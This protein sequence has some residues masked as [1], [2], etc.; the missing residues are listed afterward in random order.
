MKR[1]LLGVGI[2]LGVA[3]FALVLYLALTD[4][5]RY[6]S[7]IETAVTEATGREF[8][9]AGE[10]KPVVFPLS[11]VAED[12]SMA[13]ASWGTDEPFLTI[14]HVSMRVELASLFSGPIRIN[15]L[16]VSDVALALEENIDAENN[17]TM[18]QGDAEVQFEDGDVEGVPVIINFAEIR[19]VNVSYSRPE[20]ANR[21]ASLTALDVRTGENNFINTS[22]TGYIDELAFSLESTIGPIDKLVSGADIEYSLEAY[23]SVIGISVSG[24]TGNPNTFAGSRMQAAITADDV[25]KVLSLLEVPADLDGPLRIESALSSAQVSSSNDSAVLTIDAS[26]GEIESHSTVT[27]TD[28]YMMFEASVSPLGK[29][30]EIAGLA[31]LPDAPLTATG[32]IK[33]LRDSFELSD[34]VIAS[35]E[36]QLELDGRIPRSSRSDTE[37]TVSFS[38]DNLEELDADLPG[39]ALS[40]SATAIISETKIV[41]DPFTLRFADSDASGDLTVQLE[42][43]ISVTG[44]VHSKHLDLTPFMDA[45][46][47]TASTSADEEAEIEGNSADEAPTDEFV[48]TDE[49]LPFD[50][51]SAGF[52]DFQVTIDEFVQGPLHLE[53][54]TGAAKLEQGTLDLES[55]FVVAAGGNAALEVSLSSRE[56]NA[57]LDV[58]LDITDL[59]LS[60]S[61]NNERPVADIP[62]IGL[63]ADIESN[64]NSM[65]ALAANANG[66]VLLTQGAGKVDNSAMGF[67]SADIVA[68]LFG[69]LNPFAKD[70]PYSAWECTIFALDI[71]DGVAEIEPML[72][73]SEKLTI[74]GE[75]KIDF[76]TEALDISFNTKPRRGVGVSADMFLTPFIQLGGSMAAPRITLDKS[77]VLLSGGAAFLTGGISFFVQGAADRA[78]GTADRCAAALALAKGQDVAT[79]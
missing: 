27:F 69:A 36:L 2:F 72:A 66:K 71:V 78:S 75:G 26:A 25:A 23:L 67:F 40:S 55:G 52:A 38:T 44:Q 17:W 1:I 32:N 19:N 18:S 28:E 8:R 16:Y 76:N 42:D 4:F 53:A 68:Q 43:T 34:V 24:N 47:T 35:Q 13:N 3:A 54:L 21:I 50:L 46:Q 6:R 12:I 11:L 70:E 10:F 61:E 5:G 64:G 37:I 51:L 30:A 29:I 45:P 48:F 79:E 20:V 63:S 22:G 74:V 65:R 31:G 14:G 56:S 49:P 39:I 62:L 60:L 59:R 73:Q 7:N 41:I 9:I 15:E 33:S 58:N 57:D 77:G